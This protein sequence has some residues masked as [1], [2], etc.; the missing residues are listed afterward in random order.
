MKVQSTDA[1]LPRTAPLVRPRVDES[2][3]LARSAPQRDRLGREGG[4]PLEGGDA[5]CDL[6]GAQALGPLGT[7]ELLVAVGGDVADEAPR[8]AVA[9]A[10]GVDDAVQRIGR[11]REDA[12]P[13]DERGA[14]L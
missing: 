1:M 9:R 7:A 5:G 4:H 13:G 6:A 3:G 11:D 12:L 14:V 2:P 8:E 10:G